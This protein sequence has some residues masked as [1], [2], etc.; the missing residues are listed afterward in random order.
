MALSRMCSENY[1]ELHLIFLHLARGRGSV[2]F[3]WREI[4]HTYF[5]FY[6]WR[7][8][9]WARVEQG[10][11][12]HQTHYRSYRGRVLRVK[13]PNQQCQST[14][15][16][17][18]LRIRLQSHQ[19]HPTML[20]IIHIFTVS[21][22]MFRRSKTGERL[23]RQR[24]AI[25]GEWTSDARGEQCGAVHGGLRLLGRLWVVLV[26]WRSRRATSRRS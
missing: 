15:G 3:W 6:G 22:R 18:V 9:S 4:C 14:E 10:L 23:F 12:S 17:Q 19:V 26:C 11:T 16:R 13:W 24:W 1:T 21:E 2:L 7:Q 20:T 8:E 25:N 5:R